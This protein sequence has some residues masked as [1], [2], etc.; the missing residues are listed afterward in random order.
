MNAIV[1]TIKTAGIR[2]TRHF[3]S[4]STVGTS[5]KLS[6]TESAKGSKM[7]LPK[8]NNAISAV[9]ESS[10]LADDLVVTRDI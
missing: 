3:S 1:T 8:Y 2:R 7:S 6:K 4:R 10:A 5:T 9:P